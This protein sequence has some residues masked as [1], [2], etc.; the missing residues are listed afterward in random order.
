MAAALRAE[1]PENAGYLG[2][3]AIMPEDAGEAGAVETFEPVPRANP[4]EAAMRERLGFLESAVARM[5]RGDGADAALREIGTFLLDLLTL[6]ERDPGL[7]LAADDLYEA[8]AI[9]AGGPSIADARRWRLLKDAA[10]RFR[11]RLDAA[12]P[13]E[14][15]RRLG[16]C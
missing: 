5:E 7:E 6:V 3:E 4:F 9:L 10:R 11:E 1:T 2:S 13:G 14:R 12:H 8:A 16:L 15:A